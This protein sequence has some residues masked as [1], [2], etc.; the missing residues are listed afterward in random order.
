MHAVNPKV[1]APAGGYN[2]YNNLVTAV[3][4]ILGFIVAATLGCFAGSVD[5]NEGVFRH[6]V[7]TGRSRLALYFARIPAGLAILVPIVAAGFTIVCLVCCFAAPPKTN[8]DGLTIQS[9]LTRTEFVQF[10]ASHPDKVI[11][12]LPA[13]N[14]PI[15]VPCGPNGVVTNPKRLPPNFKMPSHASL[16]KAAKEMARQDYIQ[17]SEVFRVPPT[18]LMIK[19]GLWIE[20][21]AIIGFIVGLGLASLMGQRTVP[22][23]ILLVFTLLFT[24]LLVHQVIKHLI[25]VQRLIVGA[26]MARIEPR[27]AVARLRIEWPSSTRRFRC[28]SP[29]PCW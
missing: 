23:V 28:R 24:P 3:L 12:T 16:V 1:Y 13:R 15:N 22:V 17:Y 5:L 8:Y 9:G 10:A 20:L 2:I 21:E 4:F 18:S 14:I 26:A 6:L 25:N 7:V 11:C 27:A 29:L 19:T